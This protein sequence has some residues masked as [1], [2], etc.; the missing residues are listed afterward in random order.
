MQA[1]KSSITPIITDNSVAYFGDNLKQ[2]II[3]T[4]GTLDTIFR[5]DL[6]PYA[7][8]I[9]ALVR[10]SMTSKYCLRTS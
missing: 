5:E 6:Q 4:Q 8:N 2:L 7:V 1:I 9:L 3:D 10:S